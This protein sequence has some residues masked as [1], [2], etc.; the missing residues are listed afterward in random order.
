MLKKLPPQFFA[1][2]DVR[3]ETD[4]LPAFAVAT[5]L[6][7][8]VAHDLH[9]PLGRVVLVPL[10]PAV[11]LRAVHIRTRCRVNA[12]RHQHTLRHQLGHRRCVDHAREQLAQSLAERSSRQP[13][14]RR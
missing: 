7:H 8:H 14:H 5:P 1:M 2:L 9:A 12:H 3:A 11:D 6:G 13:D 4:R 10:T